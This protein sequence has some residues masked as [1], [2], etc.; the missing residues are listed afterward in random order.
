MSVTVLYDE[1]VTDAASAK[2]EQEHLWLSPSDFSAATGWKLETEGLCK[3]S[4]CVRAADGWTDAG[5]AIGR[6]RQL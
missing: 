2:V 5:G 6:L 3:G 4:A 1:R